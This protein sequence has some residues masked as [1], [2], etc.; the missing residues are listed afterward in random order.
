MNNMDNIED[1]MMIMQGLSEQAVNYKNLLDDTLE[2]ALKEYGRIFKMGYINFD[3]YYRDRLTT[4]YP[5]GMHIESRC[6]D[7][8]ALAAKTALI[9]SIEFDMHTG[10]IEEMLITD[11]DERYTIKDFGFYMLCE[12]YDYERSL[13]N[14]VVCMIA[15]LTKH[16]KHI[17]SKLD[18]GLGVWHDICTDNSKTE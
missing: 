5:R 15:E 14:A 1:L 7:N 16:K 13:I 4:L 8:S 18:L 2:R 6:L 3:D 17:S 10:K 11:G 9:K 12:L